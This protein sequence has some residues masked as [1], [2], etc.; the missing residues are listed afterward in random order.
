MIASK[1]MWGDGL[2]LRPQHFQQQDRYHEARLHHT[3]TALHP[4]AW[5]VAEIDVDLDALKAGVLRLNS[6]SILFADGDLVRA[7]EGDAL[8]TPV[9]LDVLEPDLQSVTFHAAL[10]C[11]K[12]HGDNCA[13]ADEQAR[14]RRYQRHQR[15]TCDLYTMAAS[16]E[17]SYLKKLVHLV[18]EF[19]ALDAF[20]SVP[21]LRLR[22]LPT[23]GFELDRSFVPPSVTVGATP[24]L[25]AMLLRLMEKLLAKVHTLYGLHREPSKHVVELRGTDMSAFWL[26]HTTST[27]YAEL[28]H[29]L[30]HAGLHPERLFG[31]LLGLAGA[32]MSYSRTYQLEDL[33]CYKHQDP[34][35]AFARIDDMIRDL[36]D[37]VVSTK[38]FSIALNNDRPSYYVGKLDSGKIDSRTALYLAVNADLPGLELVDMVPVR[39]KIGAPEDVEKLVLSAMPGVRLLYTPQA[40]SGVPMRPETYYFALD[41]KGA[42][43]DTMLKAQ[44]IS[45]YVPSG[46]RDLALDLIAICP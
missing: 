46:M 9:R 18:S 5:G 40:P 43:Y 8:P 19:D 16:S 2:F 11:L 32:L 6:L 35:P 31:Q 45:I 7:P 37:T 28:S 12:A 21:V 36:L 10:A 27:A 30:R 39:F 17:L 33:P 44:A 20:D 26:L 25:Q 23:G 14:T 15:D 38:Y 29:Y 24:V 42:L 13:N 22:R 3:A 34:G 41:A 1:V 4:Y